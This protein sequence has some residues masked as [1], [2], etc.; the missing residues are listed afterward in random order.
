MTDF[1]QTGQIKSFND[2]PEG[3][4]LRILPR[5]QPDVFDENLKLVREVE[6]LASRKGLTPAQ[7]ALGWVLAQGRKN[8]LDIIPIPGATTFERIK[9]NMSPPQLS[10][11][12]LELITEI[13]DKFP[14]VG[15][16]YDQQ[17]MAV[18]DQ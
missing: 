10:N 18:V 2:I 6:K 17:S 11:E 15:D 4:F 16:R 7:I 8:G 1:T 5:F 14:V 12:D 13:M 3:S 9:E